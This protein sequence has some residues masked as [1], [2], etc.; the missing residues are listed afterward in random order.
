[1]HSW[2]SSW[3][4]KRMTDMLLPGEW[5]VS[6]AQ[7]CFEKLKTGAPSMITFHSWY[8]G[9]QHK[10]LNKTGLLKRSLHT[11]PSEPALLLQAL[12]RCFSRRF[13]PW[14]KEWWEETVRQHKTSGP[15]PKTTLPL[16][17]CGNTR[18]KPLTPAHP[19]SLQSWVSTNGGNV[20]R[21]IKS[22][23][24]DKPLCHYHI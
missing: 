16:S 13:L 15:C 2:L 17:P 23:T 14:C 4:C 10:A 1:M 3:R 5:A 6:K 11:T 18:P 22:S 12:L 19:R 8:N 20:L 24:E 9:V 21:L 7:K